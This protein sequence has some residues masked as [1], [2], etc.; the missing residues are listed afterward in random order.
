MNA[1][2]EEIKRE[3]LSTGDGAA[4]VLRRS[5]LV[6]QTAAALFEGAFGGGPASGVALAA[7]GGY[8]RRQLF[9]CSDVDLLFL[10]ER[11]AAATAARDP[12]QTVLREM[13]DRGLRASHSVHTP[14]ECTSFAADNIELHI[15]LLDLRSLAGDRGLFDKLGARLPSF[16]SRERSEERRVGKECRL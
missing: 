8:G 2:L 11:Q 15:S 3:F 7:V 5:Q 10:F 13:W 9:P 16:Y 6:D 1:R 14:G 4:A 12:I